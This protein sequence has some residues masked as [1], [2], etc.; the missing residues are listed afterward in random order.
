MRLKQEEEVLFVS[1][2]LFVSLLDFWTIRVLP[3]LVQNILNSGS[4]PQIALQKCKKEHSTWFLRLSKS[5]PCAGNVCEILYKVQLL[6]Y[7]INQMCLRKL[8]TSVLKA[9][10]NRSRNAS[11]FRKTKKIYLKTQILLAWIFFCE[12]KCQIL[13]CPVCV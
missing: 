9:L 5:S 6:K 1:Q 12:R 4:Q 13:F 7:F 3:Q 2:C 8:R 10:G 11:E